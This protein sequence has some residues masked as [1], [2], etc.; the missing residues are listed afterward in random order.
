MSGSWQ[1]HAIANLAEYAG[2]VSVVSYVED[3]AGVDRA[4]L[5]NGVLEPLREAE[6]I[7]EEAA[8]S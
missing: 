3:P 5:Q 8:G 2:K 7:E 6:L 4:K 1:W